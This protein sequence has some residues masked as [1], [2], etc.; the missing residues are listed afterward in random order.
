MIHTKVDSSML[1]LVGY[2]ETTRILE[3]RFLKNGSR[4]RYLNVPK[5]TY[6]R[7]L[8]ASSKG[9]YMRE[10]V[11]DRY[12]YEKMEEKRQRGY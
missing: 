8:S 12:A 1:D 4:Y 9:R 10:F 6:E 7:L 2:D 3:V 5:E 11:F